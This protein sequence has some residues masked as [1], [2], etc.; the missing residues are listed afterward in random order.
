VSGLE[1]RG[2]R[3]RTGDRFARLA[4]RLLAHRT[5]PLFW[6]LVAITA[7]GTLAMHILVA[8][9]F[10]PNAPPAISRGRLLLGGN[11]A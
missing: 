1:Q 2:N 8:L 10:H 9:D 5:R 6:L 11:P 7:A 3:A 4:T